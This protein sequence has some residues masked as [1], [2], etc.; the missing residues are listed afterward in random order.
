MLCHKTHFV[1]QKAGNRKC[2]VVPAHLKKSH[3]GVYAGHFSGGSYMA[4]FVV[5]GGGLQFA[6]LSWSCAKTA[7][8][9]GLW[10]RKK[11]DASAPS[12][13]ST[14]HFQ[15][16]GMD[17]MELTITEKWNHCHCFS[18]RF[19]KWPLAFP[20][21]DQK[22]I[23]ITRLVAEEVVSMF[24]VHES[25]LSDHETNLLANTMMDVCALLGITKLNT[26]AYHHSHPSSV[27]WYGR[28][29]ESYFESHAT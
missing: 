22:A 3:G 15:I 29:H 19:D 26:T 20:P 28:T 12:D 25:L 5:T 24:G 13:L 14:A 23:R 1:D 4:Q 27:Q 11:A 16:F 10:N 18:R 21:P 17:I 2:V 7:L 9:G 6:E 8:C